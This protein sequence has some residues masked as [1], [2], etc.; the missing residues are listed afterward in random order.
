MKDLLDRRF[1][2]RA[3]GSS[4]GR[5]VTAGRQDKFTGFPDGATPPGSLAAPVCVAG[6]EGVGQAGL[7]QV[8]LDHVGHD[9][10]LRARAADQDHH[11]RLRVHLGRRRRGDVGV[12]VDVQDAQTDLGRGQDGQRV[13]QGSGAV[14]HAAQNWE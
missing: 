10:A 14:L 8:L 5:E 1:G 3:A 13:G 4:V 9:G 11:W 6:D 2:V 12:E 7:G